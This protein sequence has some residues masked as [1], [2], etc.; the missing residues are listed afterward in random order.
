MGFLEKQFQLKEKGTNLR[1]EIIAGLTTFV[2]MAYIIF[3]NPLILSGAN[4]MPAGAEYTWPQ[5]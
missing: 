5:Y 1:T 2:T 3:V 4:G